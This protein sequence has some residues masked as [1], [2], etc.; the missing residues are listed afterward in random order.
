M[1]KVKGD[2]D[3]ERY[4]ALIL[5]QFARD[6]ILPD[7]GKDAL[8][9]SLSSAIKTM[10]DQIGGDGLNFLLSNGKVLFA[11]KNGRSLYLLKRDP[12][13]IPEVQLRSKETG[14]LLQWKKSAGEKAV[15]IA[16]EKVTADEPWETIKE[17]Q[18][19]CVD[20]NLNIEKRKIPKS[21]SKPWTR[22]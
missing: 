15:L 21:K 19:I 5:S 9:T 6:G 22:P 20:R 7:S 4:F 10:R 16:S 2:T 12:E 14:A 13:G 8:V 18:L 11:F 3:S 1:G 17:N